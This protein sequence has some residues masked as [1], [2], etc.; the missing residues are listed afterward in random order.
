MRLICFITSLVFSCA[1]FV[2]AQDP[3]I[4][5]PNA[6]AYQEW[7]LMRVPGT[8]DENSGGDL[9]E[10]D[11]FAWYRCTLR[12]PGNWE[13]GNDVE[14][15]VPKVDNAHEAYFN[16]VKIGGAGKFPPAYE[17][18]LAQEN[19]YKIPESAKH[20]GKDNIIAIRV[21]DHDGRGGFKSVAPLLKKGDQA[22]N[23]DG[24]WEFRLGDDVKWA[25]GPIEV[26]AAAEYWRVFSWEEALANA[27]GTDPPLPPAEAIKTFTVPEDL[28]L[29][30]VLAEPQVQQPLFMNFDER[31]RLWVMNYRQYPDPAGL[32]MV[33]RDDFWRSVYDKLPKPPPHHT[34]GADRITIHEDTN[35]DGKYDKHKTFIDGLSIASSFVKGRGG[36]YVLNPPYLLFYPDADNNDVPDGDPEV[37]L[38]GF[39]MEDTHS[40]ANSLRWGPDGWLYAGQGSTVSGNIRKPGDDKHAIHSMGQLI[41]RYHPEKKVYEVFAEGGGNTFGVEL[42]SQGRIFSGHN[43]GDTRGFHYVQGGY[44]RKGFGKHG[45][46]SNPYTFGYFAHMTHHSVARFTH[47]FVIY[48]GVPG[49]SQTLPEK[50]HGKLFGVEPMQG[51]VVM[52]SFEPEGSTFKTEDISRPILSEDRRFRPVDIKVGP[53]GAIYVADFYEPQISH[54]EHF[55]GQIDRTN[56]RVVRLK[57]KGST[58]LPPFDMNKVDSTGLVKTL[59]KGNRWFRQAALRLLA[60]RQDKSVLPQLKQLI[61]SLGEKTPVDFVWAV[62]QLGGLTDEYAGELLMHANPYVRLWTVRLLADENKVSPPIAYKL[63]DLAR[64]EPNVEVRSQ[65]ACSAKRLPADQALPIIVN[66]LGHQ[67]DADDLHMPLLLWWALEDKSDTDGKDVVNLFEDKIFWKNRI[68]SEAIT[69]RLMRRFALSGTRQELVLAARLLAL[70]PDKQS[71]GKLLAGFEEAFKGRSLSGLPDEL[72]AALTKAGGGSLALQIRQGNAEAIATGLQQIADEKTAKADRVELVKTFGEIEQ[73][74][75]LPVL[76]TLLESAQE[77]ELLAATLSAVQSYSDAKIGTAIINRYD[78]LNAD[79]REVAQA[80]LSSRKAWSLQLLQAVSEGRIDKTSLPLDIVRKMTI[81]NDPQLSQLI[82]QQWQDLEGASSAEMQQQI[83][84]VSTLIKGDSGD[85]YKGKVLFKGSCGKCHLLYGEGGRIG[86]DLTSYK[87]DDTLR[88]LLNVVNPSAEVREGF[89]TV[90]VITDDG[91]VLNGFLADQDNRVVVIRGA[92]GQSVTV[93]RDE[94]DE[95]VPQKKSLMPEGLLSKMSDQEIRDLFAYLRGSQPIN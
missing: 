22:I 27:A 66:L 84:K 23:L 43:G 74:N 6:D 26:T 11:G 89:E 81:H 73:A 24:R 44:Y 71:Q 50:Y 41:W 35:G 93:S 36:V 47:N 90:S 68:V 48:D 63:A 40:V 78:D 58:P 54:R 49:W 64:S 61:A 2:S 18:G 37:L 32:K 33:S 55:A 20:R 70:A 67:E 14:L 88:I 31:G 56:G 25:K 62:Y 69:E 30:F 29:E 4:A 10:Y 34:P 7:T 52:S 65:L 16:G 87:R 15:F 82:T 28:E 45:P 51:Q 79:A 5:P 21:F 17:S 83:Q 76:L 60:D 59:L 53:D 39:G 94:I 8:W 9:R 86:P 85:P 3:T 75:A 77:T 92:D 42:D 46:L 12:L 13:K 38:Q 95:M 1:L 80:V 19:T 57:A 72:T 91:R